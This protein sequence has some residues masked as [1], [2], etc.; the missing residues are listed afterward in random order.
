MWSK[1]PKPGSKGLRCKIRLNRTG[2]L[3][4]CDRPARRYG[5]QVKAFWQDGQMLDVGTID[6]CFSHAQKLRSQGVIL[7]PIDRRKESK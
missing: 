3:E 7:T 2:G 6:C 5:Q 4:A 1:R